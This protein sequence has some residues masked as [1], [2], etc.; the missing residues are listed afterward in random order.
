MILL[1]LFIAACFLAY[2]NGA[3]D[4]FKWVATLFGSV[5][6]NYKKA[7]YKLIGKIVLYWIL[8][9]PIAAIMSAIVFKT[10]ELAT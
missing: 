6:T 7:D 1:L 2:N 4:N 8:T 3:N 9:L 10:L 5:T